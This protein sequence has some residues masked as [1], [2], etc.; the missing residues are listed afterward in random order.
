MNTSGAQIIPPKTL[1]Q[2]VERA[3]RGDYHAK[4]GTDIYQWFMGRTRVTV[5][6]LDHPVGTVSRMSPDE[7][8]S[9]RNAIAKATGG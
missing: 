6:G 8:K 3:R 4:I 5:I 1:A 9:A 7:A 2:Y